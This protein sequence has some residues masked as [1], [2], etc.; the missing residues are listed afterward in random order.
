MS[1]W[2]LNWCQSKGLCFLGCV[3]LRVKLLSPDSIWQYQHRNSYCGDMMTVKLSYLHNR[4][5]YT[6]KMASLSHWGQVM[7]ICIGNL[8]IIG[9]DKGLSPARHQC[10]LIV[11]WTLG[12]KFLLNFHQNTMIFI[13]ENTLKN[14][15][16]KMASILCWPQCL[17]LSQPQGSY[18]F[19]DTYWQHVDCLQLPVCFFLP[20]SWLFTVWHETN[21]GVT[22]CLYCVVPL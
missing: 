11:N 17:I 10:W 5:S 20:E 19:Y 13:Q 9:S 16:W 6:G 2:C 4:N 14:G 7:H 8:T 15:I 18:D 1:D 21:R 22:W 12:N 3:T